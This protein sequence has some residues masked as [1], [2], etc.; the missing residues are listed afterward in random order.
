MPQNLGWSI[1]PI[2]GM[3]VTDN[4]RLEEEPGL[5]N[6]DPEGEGWLFQISPAEGWN[7]SELMD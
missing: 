2:A 7:T 4:T 1:L 6:Q 3:V 5:V